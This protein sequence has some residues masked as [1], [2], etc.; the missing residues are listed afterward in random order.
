MSFFTKSNTKNYHS[1]YKLIISLWRNIKKENK[2]I[3]INLLILM[4][5]TAITE[6]LF[7]INFSFFIYFLLSQDLKTSELSNNFL[8]NTFSTLNINLDLNNIL[9]CL[10]SIT[11]ISSFLRLICL[12]R[13]HTYSAKIGNDIGTEV[14]RRSLLQPYHIHINRNSSELISAIS[15]KVNMTTDGIYNALQVIISSLISLFLVIGILTTSFYVALVCI[16]VIG[17]IY[18]AINKYT[19]PKFSTNSKNISSKQD[20]II[21]ILN[22]SF[23]GIREII[24]EKNQKFFLNLFYKND[25]NFRISIAKNRF[26]GSSSRYFLECFMVILIILIIKLSINK[27]IETSVILSMVGTFAIGFQ[28][29][30][31]A[32][33]QTYAS[34]SEIRTKKESMKDVLN[35]LEQ[36]YDIKV[37]KPNSKIDFKEIQFDSLAFKYDNQNKQLLR[38]IDLVINR[39]QMIGI[40]GNSGCGKSTFLDLLMGLLK[41]N[42]GQILVDNKDIFQNKR[43]LYK[44]QNT[45][46]HVP[47]TIFLLD[48]SIKNNIAFGQ[49][50]YYIDKN[51]IKLACEF[52][53]LSELIDELPLGIETGVG[54]RG[55]KLSGGQRQRIGLA[56]AFYKSSNLLILDEATSALDD[57]TEKR[58]IE[59][60]N[61][62]NNLTV[63][64]I[65]HRLSSLK[66]CDKIIEFEKGNKNIYDSY[67]KLITKKK[68]K[69]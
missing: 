26:M 46:S 69:N 27:N 5:F 45:I 9:I 3:I 18:F 49:S 67:N 39:N 38:D 65:A 55:I 2:F 57:D 50:E 60:I 19:S 14:F 7:L 11:I 29:L 13:I 51:R 8:I 52:A 25:Y 59:N 40:I 43:F 17:S 62:I 68:V 6:Y 63:I 30:L 22:E 41:P 48:S 12:W 44:W 4:I 47:Q 1:S 64:M 61:S 31:P 15:I 53:C 42:N 32:V 34:I 23:L 16:F 35:L 37:K 33:Q 28:K 54:E 20:K 66:Y 36:N 10:F 24:L 21:K 58:I 56:R